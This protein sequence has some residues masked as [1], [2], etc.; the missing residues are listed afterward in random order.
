MVAAQYLRFTANFNHQVDRKLALNDSEK[1]NCLL[2]YTTERARRVTENH[3]GLTNGCQPSYKSVLKQRFGQN[4]VIVEAP[5]F[6]MKSCR[7]FFSVHRR[8]FFA[9][10]YV[11]SFQH[12]KKNFKKVSFG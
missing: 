3:E 12:T 9:P 5:P 6:D 11:Q 4:T 1:M 10:Q 2:T 7:S 8:N